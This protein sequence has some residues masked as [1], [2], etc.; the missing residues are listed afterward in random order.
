[1]VAVSTKDSP[2]PDLMLCAQRP[3]GFSPDSWGVLP[4]KV[5]T[6][7]VEVA[8]AMGDSGDRLDR[9]INRQSPGSCPTTDAPAP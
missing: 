3:D 6:K 4:E 5:R 7:F 9:W 8:K 2:P 1:M